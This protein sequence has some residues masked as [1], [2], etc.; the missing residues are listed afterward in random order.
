MRITDGE[1]FAAVENHE[2][3]GGG[4]HR[5]DDVLDPDNT[6]THAAYK[7][8]KFNKLTDLF[9]SQPGGDFVDEQQ[10]RPHGKSTCKLVALPK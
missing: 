10:F 6:G 7:V 2:P 9:L 4:E 3:V 8:H 5:P 1:N